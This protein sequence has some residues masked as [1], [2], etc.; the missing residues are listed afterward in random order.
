[1]EPH[2]P[3]RCT[4][5]SS[6]TRRSSWPWPTCPGTTPACCQAASSEVFPRKERT[7]RQ[8][9]RMA[10]PPRWY[11]WDPPLAKRSAEAAWLSPEPDDHSLFE[12]SAQMHSVYA[13][14]FYMPFVFGADQRALQRLR[15]CT[16]PVPTLSE[17]RPRSACVCAYSLANIVYYTASERERALTQ[18]V[19]ASFEHISDACIAPSATSSIEIAAAK[20]CL[21]IVAFSSPF[22]LS[23]EQGPAPLKWWH[24]RPS[25]SCIHMLQS[26]RPSSRDEQ[27]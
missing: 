21:G 19:T 24:L 9:T 20:V 12:S 1:M 14:A 10:W 4:C 6:P 7:G 27:R 17:V 13:A 3:R 26:Q 23:L 11:R 22:E 16:S 15:L 25:N 5:R 18:V 8:T 2:R